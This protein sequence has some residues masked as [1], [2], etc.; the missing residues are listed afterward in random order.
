MYTTVYAV[1]VKQNPFRTRN[2]VVACI[3]IAVLVAIVTAYLV[4]D[5]RVDYA[6][7]GGAV[8]LVLWALV[9]TCDD[10]CRKIRWSQYNV[11]RGDEAKKCHGELP[12]NYQEI[13]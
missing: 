7:I 1:P 2:I 6:V 12:S 5:L 4:A 8:V 9:I 10:G 3:A 11:I 13:V